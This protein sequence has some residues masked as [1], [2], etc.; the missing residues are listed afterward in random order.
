MSKQVELWNISNRVI[1]SIVGL[2]FDLKHKA[3]NYPFLQH[4]STYKYISSQSDLW[5]GERILKINLAYFTYSDL[6]RYIFLQF[7]TNEDPVR[8]SPFL[9][10]YLKNPNNVRISADPPTHPQI[11]TTRKRKIRT[12]EQPSYYLHRMYKYHGFLRL[13]WSY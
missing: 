12:P 1:G 7:T 11:R 4:F 10:T 5:V 3:K 2:R 9:C 8:D 6:S 13:I